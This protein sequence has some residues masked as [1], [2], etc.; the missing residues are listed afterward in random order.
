MF[1]QWTCLSSITGDFALVAYHDGATI[2]AGSMRRRL[3][4][5]A[6]LPLSGVMSPSAVD[7]DPVEK[8]IYWTDGKSLPTP[9]ISRAHL[10]GSKQMIVVDDLGSEYS[11]II[12]CSFALCTYGG[13]S[14]QP[15]Y[16]S[17]HR[18]ALPL[19]YLPVCLATWMSLPL[20][21]NYDGVLV[22]RNCKFC[23]LNMQGYCKHR[24]R[25]IGAGCWIKDAVLDGSWA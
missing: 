20:F 9:G 13:S 23:R 15:V 12:P 1:C 4:D 5:F 16:L 14:C 11:I 25:G 17:T 24:P 7:Y 10:N 22:N 19:V 6:P 21:Y 8:M 2:Y 18:L 3:E